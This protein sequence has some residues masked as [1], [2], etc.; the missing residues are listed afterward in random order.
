MMY[1]FRTSLRVSVRHIWIVEILSE[2]R[3]LAWLVSCKPWLELIWSIHSALLRLWKWNWLQHVESPPISHISFTVIS[4]CQMQYNAYNVVKVYHNVVCHFALSA[5]AIALMHWL[6]AFESSCQAASPA[7]ISET[8]EAAR[9][10]ILWG[11]PRVCTRMLESMIVFQ[12]DWF[13][14]CATSSAFSFLF[15]K[16][17][18]PT[19]EPLEPF[20]NPERTF[21][22]RG[23]V[24]HSRIRQNICNTLPSFSLT[25]SKLHYATTRKL[26]LFCQVFALDNCY[27]RSA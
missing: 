21:T 6:L 27:Q 23:G 12:I 5:A 2:L 24:G 25:S 15:V 18:V 17:V 16:F 3:N 13:V 7:P 19:L 8:E 22:E 20:L 26:I 14:F 11:T 10:D 4:T 1:A 9:L